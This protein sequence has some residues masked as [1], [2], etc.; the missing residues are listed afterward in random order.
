[1]PSC[2]TEETPMPLTPKLRPNDNPVFKRFLTHCHL[3][4]YPNKSVIIYAGDPPDALYYI[5]NGAAAV[6]NVADEGRESV[7][8]YLNAGDFFG[9]M[10]LFQ[11]DDHRS[12]WVRARSQCEVAEISYNPL[13]PA[14]AGRPGHLVRAGLADGAAPAPHQQYAEP[15]C[16][17]GRR[18]PRRAHPARPREGT[19]CDDSPGRHADPHHASGTRPHRRQLARDGGQ[20]A[21]E[22]GAA[23]PHLRQGQDHRRAR[24]ALIGSARDDSSFRRTPFNSGASRPSS[25]L[26][27]VVGQLIVI[28][29]ARRIMSLTMRGDARHG[30]QHTAFEFAVAKMRLHHAT[31]AFPLRRVHAPVYAASGDDLH[32]AVGHQEINQH[33]VVMFR[34]PHLEL[35]K[36]FER[37]RARRLTAQQRGKAQR[38][39]DHHAYLTEVT[40]LALAYRLLDR[41][42]HLRRKGATHAPRRRGEVTHDARDIHHRPD[43]PPPPN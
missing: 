39:L 33:A 42:Q 34:V 6:V 3:R 16:L 28:D 30:L 8:A 25:L 43:A 37:P 2:R 26:R 11:S 19:R 40:R 36:Q 21:Q 14:R 23:E 17:H 41:R 5:T 24:R 27:R 9:E 13:S 31:Q 38:A 20:G 32:V 1:M 12:A 22:P 15:S 29:A 7:L 10:G 35:R 18:G 4:R